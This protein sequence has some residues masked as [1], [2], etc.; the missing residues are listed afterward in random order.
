[1]SGIGTDPRNAM[2]P[3]IQPEPRTGRTR[4]VS[5][6]CF[7]AIKRFL[8][9]HPVTVTYVLILGGVTGW[10][11]TVS[12]D[13]RDS[14]AQAASTNLHNLSTDPVVLLTSAVVVS[15][16]SLVWP[17]RVAVLLLLVEHLLG[18]VR[19]AAIF[20]AG[21]IGATLLVAGGL[22]IAIANNWED[23]AVRTARD[24]G[25]S[26]AGMALAGGLAVALCRANSRI[27]KVGFGL[28]VVLAVEVADPLLRDL[29]FTAVGHACA[30]VLGMSC[31]WLTT[32]HLSRPR[33][34]PMATGPF[35]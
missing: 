30:L 14:V 7:A 31:A 29:D 32:R 16:H 9:R 15:G 11:Y 25:V 19:A 3:A 20:V 13:V 28:L 23:D 6:S 33:T 27:N 18:T 17:A 8:R 5:R 4:T 12:N 34:E 26:Y 1:M 35:G 22:L 24:T 10:L 21:H 2:L